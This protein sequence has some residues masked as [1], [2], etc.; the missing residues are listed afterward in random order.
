MHEVKALIGCNN[1]I[2]LPG[3]REFLFY[4]K[5]AAIVIT[6]R[7]REMQHIFSAM[8]EGTGVPLIRVAKK[9]FVAELEEAITL[10]QPTIGLLKTFPFVIPP[11]ILSLPPGG[12]VNFHYGLLPE[13]RGPQPVLRHLLNNDTHAGVTVHKMDAGIDTGEIVL[14]ER[15]AID[16]QDTYG[17]LQSKL[18]FLGAKLSVDL[19]KILS[20]GS[21]LPSVPQD[22]SKARY[23]EMPTADELTIRWDRMTAAEI[24][25]LVNAC[26]PWNKGAGTSLENWVVGITEVRDLG[27]G[28][29]DD[30]A[31][32]TILTCNETEGLVVKTLDN[33]RLK[34]T[35]IYTNEGYFSGERMASLGWKEGQRLA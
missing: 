31:P 4:G 21:F 35:I 14:Q 12:F 1:P 13:C 26:N 11:Q 34:L 15:L 8:L 19:L 25:R 17:M 6:R 28:P 32:G 5:V 3:I 7:N 9:T 29:A 23:L 27:E 2:A 18:G 24:R 30:R 16:P 10:N 33:H 22:E 20:Y